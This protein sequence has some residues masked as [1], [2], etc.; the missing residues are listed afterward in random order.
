MDLVVAANDAADQIAFLAGTLDDALHLLILPGRHH[1]HH[2]N[3]HVE[4]AHHVILRDIADLLHVSKYRQRRPRAHLYHG[5][6]PFRHHT[7]QIVSDAAPGDVGHGVNQF[8][9]DQLAQDRPVALVRA[10]ELVAGLVLDVGN[11]SIRRIFRHFKEELARQGISIGVQA[12]GGQAYKHVAGFHLIAGDDL[13][14]IYNADDESSQI[15]LTLWIKAGH[16]GRLAADQRT[17]VMAA[18][19]GNSFNNLFRNIRLQAAGRQVVHEEERT[20]PLNGNVVHAMVGKVAAYGMVQPHYEGDFQFGSHTIHAGNQ[21][22]LAEFL[23]IDGEQAAE[24]ADL[25]HDAAGKGAMGK[26]LDALLGPVG[27]VDIDAAIGVSDWSIFQNLSSIW[28]E[29]GKEIAIEGRP[30][31]TVPAL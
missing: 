18:G 11:V 31:L 26:V 8:R 22:R 25:A 13:L 20:G 2:A 19:F 27:T 5:S 24:A 21:H 28:C 6:R 9:I 12:V 4:S 15:V 1:Q 17:S 10:H 16:L 14:L 30:I 7:G 29:L 3:A 23:F